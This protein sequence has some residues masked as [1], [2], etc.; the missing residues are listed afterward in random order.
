MGFPLIGCL[1]KDKLVHLQD[2]RA[3]IYTY[4]FVL[5]TCILNLA[6]NVTFT[7]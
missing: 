5:F 1:T 6:T 3:I 4:L 2:I 7:L